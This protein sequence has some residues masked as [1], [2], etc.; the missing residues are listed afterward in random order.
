MRHFAAFGQ[1]LPAH[2]LMKKQ[3]YYERVA[4]YERE[5]EKVL[6]TYMVEKKAEEEFEDIK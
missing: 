6:G 3:G 4:K 1:E 2:D 5:R